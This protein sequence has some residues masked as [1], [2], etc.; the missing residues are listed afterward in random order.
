MLK[1]NRPWSN[2]TN[3]SNIVYYTPSDHI[4]KY[5]TFKLFLYIRPMEQ[6]GYKHKSNGSFA[7]ILSK[8]PTQKAR[9]SDTKHGRQKLVAICVK[10]CRTEKP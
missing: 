7:F 2:L 8:N 1:Y 10:K 3:K 6:N 5:K 9:F 4:F